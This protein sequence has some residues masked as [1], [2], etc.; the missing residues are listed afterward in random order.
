M[1]SN[2]SYILFLIFLFLS[3]NSYTQ[4]IKNKA[5]D[6]T[7]ALDTIQ[8]DSIIKPK[9]PKEALDFIITHDAFGSSVQNVRKKEVTLTDK[10]HIIY[11]DIDLKAG[12]II[13]DYDKNIVFAKG[14]FEKDSVTKKDVYKQRPVFKQGKEESQQDSIKFNYKTKKALV[15]GVNTKQGEMLVYG[16]KTKR[17]NDSTIYIRN[18][19]FTTSPKKKPDYYIATRKAKLVP[20]K[21]IIVGASNMVIA[22]VPTPLFLPFAYFPLEKKRTSGFLMP[23]W[24]ENSES[25]FLQNGGYYFVVNDYLDIEATGDIYSNGSWAL[26]SRSNYYVRYKYSGS[27]SFRY[28]NL[29]SSIK[30]FDNYSK[31]TS[32]NISWNHSQ[33]SKN[34]PNS[35]L[36]ASVNL[37][38]SKF[39]KESMNEIDMNKYLNNTLNS[40]ISYYKKFV[41]TPF[42]MN[43][44]LN[45]SQN[46]NTETINMTLPSL[47]L[48]MDRQYPFQGK[49]GVKRNAFQKISLSYN[50]RGQYSIR[51]NDDDFLTKR[52]WKNSRKGLQHNLNSSTNFKLFKYFTVSPRAS[53]TDVWYFDYIKK[54]YDAKKK[55]RNGTFGTVVTDTINGFKR[56]NKYNGGA[57]LST[58]IYG[59][60]NFNGKRLKAIRHTMQPSISWSYTPDVG[61]RYIKTVQKSNKPNDLLEYTEFEGGLYGAP[62]SFESN[63]M[64]FSLNNTFEAKVKSKDENA[65]E[66]EYKKINLLNNLSLSTSYNMVAKDFKWSN[67]SVSTGTTLF[68]NRLNI[69]ARGSF[70]PYKVSDKGKRI[71]EFDFWLR[72]ASISSNFSISN[73]DFSKKETSKK[74]DKSKN[75]PNN[76]EDIYDSNNFKTNDFA[77]KL[78]NKQE[79]KK[80]VTKLYNATIPWR[81]GF[82]YLLTYSNNG[83]NKKEISSHTLGFNG[84]I[85]FS[86]KWK[87]SFVSGYDLKRKDFSPTS[88]NFSRDLDSFRF[89]FSWVPFGER[90][91][92]H[93]FI[94]IK[95]SMLSDLKWDKIKPP[96]KRLY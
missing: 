65:E 96:D 28:Q 90:T 45:H 88:L 63:S 31:R 69:N 13:I 3:T 48:N 39:Y 94:G 68:K 1:K 82:I 95:S 77:H 32:Y 22:D 18:I 46:S 89:N 4:S 42:N 10:A 87:V 37:G 25:F 9:K 80:K 43:V 11:N 78:N 57:S 51:T 70:D 60:F 2:L 93:F 64:S 21:K 53:Y 44:S 52:M 49:G 34:S 27:F 36:S 47:S 91:S 50:M 23:S 26:N 54:R 75:D 6:K 40:S 76:T 41:G 86:P 33:D 84:N 59:M 72:S 14:I 16:E 30:G 29:V 61:K 71:E 55:N 24:G 58:T 17:V 56:F 38:S 19:K 73:K 20:G 81:I 92:Y 74:K 12:K 7:I 67:V 83:Y 5:K 79:S 8:K 66:D 35:R 85:E 15:Y 62:S